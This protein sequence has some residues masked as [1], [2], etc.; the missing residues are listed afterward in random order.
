MTVAQTAAE[1]D[2]LV[3]A[4]I[5][6]IEAGGTPAPAVIDVVATEVATEPAKADAPAEEAKPDGETPPAAETLNLELLAE[7]AD[8]KPADPLQILQFKAEAPADYD[9]QKSALRAQKAEALGKMMSG[10]IST[11]DYA[12]IEDE[13]SDKIEALSA[14][15][16]R[17]DTL[18]D[19]NTQVQGQSQAQVIQ[20]VALQAK[21]VDGIDYS[22]DRDAANQ[23]DAA[24]AVV[25]VNPTNAAKP[26]AE[27]AAMAHK[28]VA[29]ARQV[30]KP[31]APGQR[32]APTRTPPAAPVTLSGLPNAGTS[33]EKTVDAVLEGLSG[34]EFEAAFDALP[35]SKKLTF[36]KQ[37]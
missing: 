26:F 18:T 30:D 27:Q 22:T 24:L 6:A 14:A 16:I 9:A 36:F 4:E 1:H 31:A 8:D 32:G 7:I 20:A 33:T 15:R 5:A 3:E 29:L 17:A 13:V 25:R 35:E 11:E 2:A 12:K 37:R 19:V 23:F 34:P 10:E 21:R 28:M